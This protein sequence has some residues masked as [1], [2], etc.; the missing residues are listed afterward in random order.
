MIVI[1]SIIALLNFKFESKPSFLLSWPKG[2]ASFSP[3]NPMNLGSAG[4]F[5]IKRICFHIL[6]GRYCRGCEQDTLSSC[7]G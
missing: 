6:R 3:V 4:L 2:L 1:F 5:R 7:K